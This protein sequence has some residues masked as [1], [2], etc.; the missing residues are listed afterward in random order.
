MD[1]LNFIPKLFSN[2]IFHMVKVLIATVSMKYQTN[3]TLTRWSCF[4]A[5]AKNKQGTPIKTDQSVATESKSE[6]RYM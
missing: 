3:P 5:K 4:K 6:P 2:A 1:N